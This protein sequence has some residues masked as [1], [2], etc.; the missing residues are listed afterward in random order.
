MLHILAHLRE[1]LDLMTQ[2]SLKR[3]RIL[4]LVQNKNADSRIQSKF[5][6]AITHLVHFKCM[7]I[8]FAENVIPNFKTHAVMLLMVLKFIVADGK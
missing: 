8:Y 5:M 2:H 4:C 6:V 1:S 3:E 7:S